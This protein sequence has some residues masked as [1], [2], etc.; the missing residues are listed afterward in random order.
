MTSIGIYSKTASIIP[1]YG[2]SELPQ[3][4]ARLSAV[5]GGMYILRRFPTLFQLENSQIKSI[6]DNEKQELKANY[7]VCNINYIHQLYNQNN[8]KWMSRC[9]CISDKSILSYS[10]TTTTTND[11]NNNDNNDNNEQMNQIMIVIP[12]ETIN[13]NKHPIQILQFDSTMQVASKGKCKQIKTLYYYKCILLTKF[14]VSC[15][16]FNDRIIKQKS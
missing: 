6:V 16:P 4:F 10:T 3:A 15:Y 2:I 12:P 1:M 14:N 9:I 13:N 5:F 11:N 8:M 7:F